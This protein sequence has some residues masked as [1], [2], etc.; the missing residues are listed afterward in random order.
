MNDPIVPTVRENNGNTYWYAD[1]ACTIFHR[2]GALAVMYADGSTEWCRIGKLHR[3]DG[4]AIE[5]A[6]G[7]G[8]KEW[9]LDGVKLTKAEHTR[10]TAPAQEMTVAQIESALG[11]KVKIVK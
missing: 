6:P 11:Y 10:L 2:E 8:R 7:N 3:D 4:P 9:W 5:P 1:E